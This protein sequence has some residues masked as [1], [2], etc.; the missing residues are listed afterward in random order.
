MTVAI[1]FGTEVVI[2]VAAKRATT[3]SFGAESSATAT[4]LTIAMTAVSVGMANH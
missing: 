1:A 3:V 4:R 2:P